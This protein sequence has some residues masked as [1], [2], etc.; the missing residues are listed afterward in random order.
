MGAVTLL[1]H[2]V[3]IF[4]A[5]RKIIVGVIK[6]R[7]SEA[8]MNFELVWVIDILG[9]LRSLQFLSVTLPVMEINPPPPILLGGEKSWWTPAFNL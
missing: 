4:R 8:V 9:W 5:F 3:S 2:H 6:K 7:S 1:V